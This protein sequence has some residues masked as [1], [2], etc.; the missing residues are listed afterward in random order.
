MPFSSND[1]DLTRAWIL[2]QRLE[3][4]SKN[5]LLLKL[6][7]R[8]SYADEP[9][10][11]KIAQQLEQPHR[12]AAWG[13]IAE[14]SLEAADIDAAIDAAVDAEQKVFAASLKK[15]IQRDPSA[16][17]ELIQKA[18]PE[19]LEWKRIANRMLRRGMILQPLDPVPDFTMS[20]RV[21]NLLL[22]GQ[23]KVT[24]ALDLTEM[25]ADPYERALCHLYLYDMRQKL[26]S[27]VWRK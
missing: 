19:E 8:L 17:I 22:Y 5:A 10:A 27:D 12:G 3:G 16:G 23:E 20:D 15:K 9:L 14:V 18:F 4:D 13:Y 21:R 6:V 1:S 25:V 11:R 7:E 2:S 26:P 24:E